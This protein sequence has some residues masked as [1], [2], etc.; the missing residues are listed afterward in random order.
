M[1][2]LN[3][4]LGDWSKVITDVVDASGVMNG[5]VQWFIPGDPGTYDPA[6]DTYV[7]GTAD[8]VVGTT[9]ARIQH[10]REPRNVSTSYEWTTYRRIRVQIPYSAIALAY[11]GLYPSYA[12]YPSP[13]LYPS[14]LLLSQPI[15]K[16]TRGLITNGGKDPAL[17]GRVLVVESAL[18]SS[19][20]ALRTVEGVLEGD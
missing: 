2:T 20:A 7:G 9:I 18:N 13:G 10:L 19:W 1:V 4:S 3:T 15:T 14:S 6:T 8:S 16:G 11:T 17:V 5:E 12:Y